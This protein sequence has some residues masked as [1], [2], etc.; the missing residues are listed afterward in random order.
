M[1]RPSFR[2]RPIDLSKPLPII[3][4]SKDLRHE[5]DIVV[6]RALPAIATGVD[7]AEEEERHLQAALLAS[8]FGS[9]GSLV[10]IPVPVVRPVEPPVLATDFSMGN[11]YIMFDR[12]DEDLEEVTVEYDADFEDVGLAKEFGIDLGELEVVLDGFEKVQGRVEGEGLVAFAGVRGVCGALAESVRK[13][14]YAHWVR[15]RLKRGRA[16]LRMYQAVPDPADP[17][18]AVAFRPRDREGGARR[19]NTFDNFKRARLLRGELESLRGVLA[20]VVERERVKIELAAVTMLGQRLAVCAE[21]GT[22]LEALNRAFFAGEKEN[23]V[24][25]GEGVGRV[26][27]PCRSLALPASVPVTTR[28]IGSA[29]SEKAPSKKSRKKSLGSSKSVAE[30]S[31]ASTDPYFANSS[32][33]AAEASAEARAA[34]SAGLHPSVDNFGFDEHGNKFLKHMRYFAGGFM[35]YGVCP[36]DHR[37]FAAASE[38]NTVRELPREPKPVTFPSPHIRFAHPAPQSG[39]ERAERGSGRRRGRGGAKVSFAARMRG[40]ANKVERVLPPELPPVPKRR[41]LL[42]ARGRVGRGGRIIFDRVVFEPERGVKAASYPASVEMGGV[43][44]AGIPLDAAERVAASVQMGNIGNVS[45]LGGLNARNEDLS[46]WSS[47]G[48][49]DNISRKLIPPLKPMAQL[50]TGVSS[51]GI[52]VVDAW[53]KRRRRNSLATRD[54]FPCSLSSHQQTADDQAGSGY[55]RDN[56]ILRVHDK[57]WTRSSP[58]IRCLPAFSPRETPLVTEL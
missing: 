51:T 34:A 53:P 5:D 18:P 22:R 35:N 38:R 46:D 4:T 7:P 31:R 32:V 11:E 19:M 37:V 8:V 56:N 57:H 2:P 33:R 30:K 28:R 26:V 49:R 21:A 9:Q 25:Y 16:F 27:V 6:N 13:D 39:D 52:D 58:Q 17:S 12:S 50:S 40:R 29:P 45:V 14:V 10:D 23:V 42:R 20:A 15:R 3:K 36:Y 47:D 24:V 1:S 43:Y 55:D 48:G 41:K 54:S 44:T